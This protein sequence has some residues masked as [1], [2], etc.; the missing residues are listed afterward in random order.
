LAFLLFAGMQVAAMWV[1]FLRP[2][3]NR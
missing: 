1:S 2:I 3:A